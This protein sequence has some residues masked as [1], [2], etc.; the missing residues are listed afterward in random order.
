M[1]VSFLSV[2]AFDANVSLINSLKKKSE[3]SFFTEALHKIYNY[4]DRE[5][6]TDFITMGNRVEQI[7]RFSELIP[8]DKTFVIKGTRASHIIKKIYNSYKIDKVLKKINP[9]VIIIDNITLTYFCSAIRLRNKA[10]LIVHDPFL[11]SGEG[12]ILDKILR[13]LFFRLIKNKILLNNNQKN[14]FLVKNGQNEMNVHS[15]FLSVY[16]YLTYYAEEKEISATSNNKEKEFNILFF[17]RISPYKG[18]KF[19]LDTYSE[20]CSDGKFPNI[21]LTI[22]GNGDFDFDINAYKLLP[23]LK[24]V[25]KFI[26]PEEL[27]E[28]IQKSSVVVCPYT[29]ATQSGVIMSAFAFKKPVIATNVGGLPEMVTHMET[30]IIIEKNNQDELKNAF[31]MLYNNPKLLEDMSE[32]INKEYFEGIKSWK[33]SGELF[34]NAIESIYKQNN[35]VGKSLS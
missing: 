16:E 32:A 33:H 2:F 6:L 12:N 8:L 26:E 29:D 13:K 11:H 17:G 14:E 19:L 1:K 9:D 22:A 4:I 15:S 28:L 21:T 25:N 10:L 18:I 7:K 5:K 23:N 30:G 24:I 34:F 20:L 27:S 3:I 31:L 35:K